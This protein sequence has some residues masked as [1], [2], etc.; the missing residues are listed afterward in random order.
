[1]LVWF[2]TARVGGRTR[3]LVWFGT[4]RDGGRTRMPVC[5]RND[6]S[7]VRGKRVT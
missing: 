2:G 5:I 1:M 7:W 3:M 6:K 4:A